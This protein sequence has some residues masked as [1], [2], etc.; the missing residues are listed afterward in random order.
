MNFGMYIILY[1]S[2]FTYNSFC[3]LTLLDRIVISESVN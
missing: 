3:V 1:Y 2:I